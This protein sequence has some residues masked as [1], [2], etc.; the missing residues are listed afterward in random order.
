MPTRALEAIKH[1]AQRSRCRRKPRHAARACSAKRRRRRLDIVR[2]QVRTCKKPF[3]H[4]HE[5]NSYHCE[6]SSSHT[7]GAKLIHCEK[8]GPNDPPSTG[9][10]P[11]REKQAQTAEASWSEA[12]K[13]P[14][15]TIIRSRERSTN[16]S[17][18]LTSLAKRRNPNPFG[19][20]VGMALARN[21]KTTPSKAKSTSIRNM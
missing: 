4:T 17:S 1:S 11:P 9:M 21:P 8:G 6:K 19:S 14:K 10:D 15:S 18:S 7:L 5:A 16:E 3:R 13:R 12:D 20:L 2:P